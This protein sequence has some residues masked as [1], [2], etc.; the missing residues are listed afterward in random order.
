M[1]HSMQRL[2]KKDLIEMLKDYNDTDYIGTLFTV[3]DGKEKECHQVFVFF[4]A[5]ERLL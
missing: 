1:A 2:S 3:Q 5:V 4:D